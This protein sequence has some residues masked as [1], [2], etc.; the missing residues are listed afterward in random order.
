MK[1]Q[2]TQFYPAVVDAFLKV[3]KDKNLLWNL[4][5]FDMTNKRIFLFNN[6]VQKN[7]F[8][9]ISSG[10]FYFLTIAAISLTQPKWQT[11]PSA[12]FAVC[13]SVGGE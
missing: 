12:A 9:P 4:S 2:G 13:G 11:G 8:L 5:L 6:N 7:E 10:S 3:M 1:N